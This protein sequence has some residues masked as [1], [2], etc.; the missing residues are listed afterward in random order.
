MPSGLV[1]L[2]LSLLAIVLCLPF[3]R[4]VWLL[5]DEGV[6]LHGAER[7]LHGN[8]IYVD[9]FEFLPPGCFVITAA[10]FGIAGTSFLAARILALLTIAAVVSFTFLACQRASKETWSS[11]LIAIAPLMLSEGLWVQD[12]HHWF[13]TLFSLLAACAALAIAESPRHG[14]RGP[15]MAGLAAGAAVMITPN[16]GALAVLAAA[17]PFAN[18]R[19][20]WRELIIYLLGTATVPIS[21]FAYLAWNGTLRGAYG[22]VVLFTVNHYTT[23]N[24]V[25]FGFVASPPL[26]YLF[27]F[28]AVLTILICVRDRKTFF[29]N[30]MLQT[31]TAFGLAGFIGSYPRPDQYHLALAAP[32]A[33]PLLAYCVRQLT[34]HWLPSRRYAV[35]A[36][37]IALLMPALYRFG[38][39]ARIAARWTQVVSTPGGSVAVLDWRKKS[40]LIAQIAASPAEDKY[41]FY[42]YDAM[43]PFLTKRQQV[44]RYDIFVPEYTLPSQYQETCVSALRSA[45]WVVI[46]RHWT[47]PKTLKFVFPGMQNP[48]PPETRKFEDALETGFDFVA[49]YG[50]FELRHRRPGVDVAVCAGIAG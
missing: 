21:V 25:P 33:G 7:L 10:W 13:T 17:T 34:G 40:K 30:R 23:I 18:V 47:D 32:L 9:F 11:A 36:V 19:R 31:C 14:V 22:D 43:L 8:R 29:K 28:T 6:V 45:S 24:H 27:P 42:P 2:I 12:V 35:F 26:K 48:D 38:W 44:S 15:L 4:Y 49:R 46:D 5:G 50:I 1:A 16:R 39:N 37:A 20:Y 41:F 3:A